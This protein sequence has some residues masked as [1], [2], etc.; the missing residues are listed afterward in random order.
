MVGSSAAEI[1]GL[2]SRK[3][4]P[5]KVPEWAEH[6][7]DGILVREL[8]A[9]ARMEVIGAMEVDA[10]AKT[11]SLKMGVV[12]PYITDLIAD[13]ATGEPLFELAMHDTLVKNHPG[14]VSRV[15]FKAFEISRIGAE[16]DADAEGNS[17]GAPS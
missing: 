7:P 8:S 15:A 13:P 2:V 12:I 3:S 9:D 1:L 5:M 6:Q 11:G 4:V 17:E 14:V 16:A 10:V